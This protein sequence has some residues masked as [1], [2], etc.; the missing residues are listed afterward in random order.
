MRILVAGSEGSLMQAVIP[1]LIANGHEIFGVDNLQRYGQRRHLI[2]WNYKFL[3]GDLADPLVVDDVFDQA[4]PD[5]VINAAARIYGIGGFNKYKADI[6]GEDVTLHNNILK[7]SSDYTVDRVVYV[8]SS[9]VY[10]TLQVPGVKELDTVNIAIPKTDYGLS[11]LVGERLSQAFLD[12][13]GV[14]YTI[15]RPFNIITPY[16]PREREQGTSHVFADFIQ[17]IAINKLN[18][19]PIIGDGSQIRC[20]TW[21]N[22]V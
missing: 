17:N 22:D 4:R 2:P 1:K 9:M 13:Y 16:E 20:F 19:L 15:W 7:A 12:Q 8:S 3:R 21:I 6:L 10:E 11:K 14:N 18:P 5:A